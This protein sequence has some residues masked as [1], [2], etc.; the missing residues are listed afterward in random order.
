MAQIWVGGAVED[1]PDFLT[2]WL[3]VA[4]LGD[5]WKCRLVN[6]SDTD[7]IEP[8]VNLFMRFQFLREPKFDAQV[9]V[10]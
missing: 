6:S 9:Y 10:L 2:W 4:D 7:I 8:V 5:G 1:V 3:L